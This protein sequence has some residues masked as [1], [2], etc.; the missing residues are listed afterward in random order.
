MMPPEGIAPEQSQCNV[1]HASKSMTDC[2]HRRRAHSAHRHWC[3]RRHGLRA[4][5]PNRGIRE[6][7]AL[8]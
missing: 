6:P 1:Q 2:F 5:V 8:V 4:A 3:C 7:S